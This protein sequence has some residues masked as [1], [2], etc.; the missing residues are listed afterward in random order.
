M[1]DEAGHKVTVIDWNER[2]FSRLGDGF[3]GRTV[4]GNAIEQDTLKAAD[5]ESADA[6][7]AATS[8]D[9]RNIMT[10]EVA[11]SIFGVPKVIARIK[12]PVRASIY[13]ELGLECDC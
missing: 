8:G 1:L 6:F 9:N 13:R 10:S 3:R 12:D 7:L 5:V 11:K 2:A 4:L